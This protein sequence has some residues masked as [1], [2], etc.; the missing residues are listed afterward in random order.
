MSGYAKKL[1]EIAL[2]LALAAGVGFAQSPPGQPPRPDVPTAPT[3]T[4][5]GPTIGSAW[6][7]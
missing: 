6:P 3:A 4:I 1:L 7:R 5:H 2:G